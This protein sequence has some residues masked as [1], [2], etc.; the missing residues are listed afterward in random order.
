MRYIEAKTILS[1][2]RQSDPYFGISYNMNLY[3]G[4]QHACVYCDTRSECYQVGDIADI[5][6]KEN[7]IELLQKELAG[8]K[9][10]A[11]IGTGSM[12]DPYMQIEKEL[13]L[14]R[15]A[16]EV[17][18]RR[19]FPVH[20]ITKSNL[21]VRDVDILK[22]VSSTYGAVSLTI[23]TADDNL[24]KEIEPNAPLSSQRF[25]AIEQLSKNGI[26]TGI[27]MMP[28][29]PFINDTKDNIEAILKKAG[30]AG[31]AYI[32]PMLG[33]TL[34]KGSREYLYRFFEIEYP[35]MKEKYQQAFGE[36]Y[37]CNPPGYK[38]LYELLYEQAYKY[39]IPTKMNFYQPDPEKQLKLF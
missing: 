18:A 37:I 8:K 24:A 35:G 32:I 23:T 33:V 5:R 17:I 1:K 3:R 20:I 34:R 21:V 30:D 11:T 10:K 14:T 2:L 27:T 6:V 28:L 39:S 36:Q 9:V 29:L 12:N 15:K 16:L 26:Y 31:A 13:E 22:D 38:M 25:K 7:A 4:C 19:K